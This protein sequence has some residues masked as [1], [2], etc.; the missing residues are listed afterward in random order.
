V[1]PRI[2]LI[3]RLAVVGCA[4]GA[5][6]LGA[7]ATASAA[8]LREPDSIVA[9][10]FALA[11]ARLALMPDVAA[12]KWAT[13]QAIADPARE[14]VVLRAAGDR[15]AALGLAREPVESLFEVQVGLARDVQAS[16]HARWRAEGAPASG[17]APSLSATLRPRID[18]L[19]AEFLEVLYLAA[20]LLRDVDLA[21]V[22]DG[23]LPA[24]RWH[25]AD[26]ARFV[27]ALGR[28]R[29]V[30]PRTPARAQAAGVLRIGTPGDYAPFA[31]AV[32]SQ[33]TGSDVELAERLSAAL[34]LR[35]VFVHT[36]W[37]TLVDDL[38]ADH[39]DLAVGGIS[40][41]EARLA[42]AAFSL[43]IAQGGK[44]AIGRCEDRARFARWQDID[45][46]GVIVVENAGGMNEQFARRRLQHATLRVHPDNRTVMD[47]LVAARADVM[48]T[49][50]TE[51]VLVTRRRPV[52]CRLLAERFD[53]SDKALLLPH[54]GAWTAAVD[55]WLRDAIAAGL[56][57]SL[58]ER[59]LAE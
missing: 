30:A 43:P 42:R 47:E 29:L 21:R 17:S 23:G 2:R 13:G 39:F 49:D 36:R 55:G 45:R 3:V 51:V 35:P 5:L 10:I 11:D 59:Q 25:D 18:Q 37:A 57:A 31:V 7:C 24:T 14:A 46:D 8:T 19:T 32:A 6:W 54:D 1:Q 33:L 50:D 53:P 22:A 52:L 44:T 34:G 27:A 41:T 12:A 40:V 56:P 58:L 28:V 9:R 15:A 48:F 16:L 20:P 26:R 4:V 38:Q